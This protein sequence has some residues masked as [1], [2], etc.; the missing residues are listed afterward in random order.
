MRLPCHTDQVAYRHLRAIVKL[1]SIAHSI[2]DFSL[3]T[4]TLLQEFSHDI[5][6]EEESPDLTTMTD[7]GLPGSCDYH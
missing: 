7:D 2:L 3:P 6:Q 4:G 5:I 1:V